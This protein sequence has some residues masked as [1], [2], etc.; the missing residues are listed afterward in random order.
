[1]ESF[2]EMLAIVCG[3]L[4]CFAEKFPHKK[5]GSLILQ[6]MMFLFEQE[7]KW[8]LGFSLNHRGPFS[9]LVESIL[10]R[11]QSAG[12]IGTYPYQKSGYYIQLLKC[13]QEVSD[14]DKKLIE[15]LVEKYGRL[16]SDDLV[17]LTTALFLK[18]RFEVESKSQLIDLIS[19]SRPQMERAEIKKIIN[20]IE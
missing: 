11:A 1:M 7:K 12:N 15:Q 17:I 13:P 8:N 6:K 16:C 2:E 5:V 3:F 10:I 20:L 9:E 14:E 4:K 18:D 19:E